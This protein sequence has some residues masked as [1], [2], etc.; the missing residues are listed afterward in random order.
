RLSRRLTKYLEGKLAT[1]T[2]VH[3]GL[4]EIYGV[5]VRI[6]G[7][8]GVGKRET[9]LESVKRGRRLGADDREEKSQEDEDMEVGR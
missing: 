7:Q 8:S 9:A 3:G 6:R 1:T 2:A 5:G 4:E